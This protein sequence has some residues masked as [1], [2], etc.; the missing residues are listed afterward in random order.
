M[1]LSSVSP[2]L[3]ANQSISRSTDRSLSS[4]SLPSTAQSIQVAGGIFDLIEKGLDI[5]GGERERAEER[6]RAEQE[7]IDR[8]AADE[9][10]EQERIDRK[11]EAEEE[12]KKQA[13]AEQERKRVES[14]SPE[15]QDADKAKPDYYFSFSSNPDFCKG[16]IVNG[17]SIC[18]LEVSKGD[19]RRV[20]RLVVFSPDGLYKTITDI[21]VAK[22]KPTTTKQKEFLYWVEMTYANTK[23]DEKA[24][25]VIVDAAVNKDGKVFFVFTELEGQE[26]NLKKYDKEIRLL[27][28]ALQ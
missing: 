18:L 22:L 25:K 26:A 2:G 10:A 23:I 3:A 1:S 8:K 6:K 11:A 27:L 24:R 19:T 21:T 14:P 28:S 4:Q 12:A 5:V 7:R 20:A 16:Q 17:G 15:P 9:R 13:A